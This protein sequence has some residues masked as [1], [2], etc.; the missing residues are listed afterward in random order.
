MLAD[1]YTKPL[2]GSAF[3]NL[4]D[5]SQGLL[6]CDVLI[7]KYSGFVEGSE[8]EISVDE[9]RDQKQNPIAVIQDR[10]EHVGENKKL[11]SFE[12]DV[13]MSDTHERDKYL[14]SDDKYVNRTYVD[15]VRQ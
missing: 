11:V 12:K 2:Q 14:R 15:V 5:V 8:D 3:R 4:R 7:E 6:D 13:S 10:K 9:S 1:F